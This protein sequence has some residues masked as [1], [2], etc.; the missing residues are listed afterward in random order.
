[1]HLVDPYPMT[2]NEQSST[3]I[4]TLECQN[5]TTSSQ[6]VGSHVHPDLGLKAN[7]CPLTAGERL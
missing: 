4:W 5:A 3:Q 7:Q 2:Q 6:E 1:M